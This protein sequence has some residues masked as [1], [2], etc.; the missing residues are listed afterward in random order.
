MDPMDGGWALDHFS[1]EKT[2]AKS[3]I[4]AC[5]NSTN[6]LPHFLDALDQLKSLFIRFPPAQRKHRVLTCQTWVK[7]E[8]NM[9]FL[10]HD[11]QFIYFVFGHPSD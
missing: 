1:R 4:L 8:T 9:R 10:S 11:D 5:R 3:L 7:T 6:D 2:R